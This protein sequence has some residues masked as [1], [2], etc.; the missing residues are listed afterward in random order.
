MQIL[1][2]VHRSITSERR[3]SV[4]LIANRTRSHYCC[5]AVF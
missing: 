2:H 1:G 5:T 4:P 3:S